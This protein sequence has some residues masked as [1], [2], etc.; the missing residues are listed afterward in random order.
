VSI[1]EKRQSLSEKMCPLFVNAALQVS[2]RE[3]K[4][5]VDVEAAAQEFRKASEKCRET[6]LGM[7]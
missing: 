2:R 7:L 6:A 5:I 1:T 3:I 4:K